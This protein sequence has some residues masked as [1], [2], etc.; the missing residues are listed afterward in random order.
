MLYRKT[1][2]ASSVSGLCRYLAVEGCDHRFALNERVG[3]SFDVRFGAFNIARIGSEKAFINTSSE[4]RWMLPA[5]VYRID[6][7]CILCSIKLISKGLKPVPFKPAKAL[8]RAP[9]TL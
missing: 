1:A 6:I 5:A 3:Q 7:E 8:T 4:N 9:A 2:R